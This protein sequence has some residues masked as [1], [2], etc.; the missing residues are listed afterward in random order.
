[1]IAVQYSVS[2]SILSLP[3]IYPL[4]IEPIE[5]QMDT[6]INCA[7]F[8]V[9]S[10]YVPLSNVV[11][12]GEIG[13]LDSSCFH[14]YRIQDRINNE[15]HFLQYECVNFE[16]KTIKKYFQFLGSDGSYFQQEISINEAL[17]E[18]TW[19]FQGFITIPSQKQVSIYLYEQM[20][21]IFSKQIQIHFPLEG[22]N[23]NL[24]IG[25]HFKVS[26]NSPLY[27]YENRLLSFFPGQMDYLLDFF[28]DQPEYFLE[29]IEE[30]NENQCYCLN[31][32]K[33][34]IEDVIIQQQDQF[35]FVSQ[36][37]N[38]DKFLLSGWIK[39]REINS[40]S[41]EFYY[42][43]FKLSGNFLNSQLTQDNLSAFQLLYKI[44]S[45][46]NQ[47]I[48]KSY[49]Y[50]FPTVNI[51]FS[52]NP[53]LKT[54]KFDINCDIQLW[55]YILIEK[56]ET[57]IS[58]SITFY[59]GFDQ[60]Q[61]NLNILVNHFNMVQFKLLYGNILKSKSDYLI[62]Q[63][64]G[65]KFFNCPDINQPNINCHPTCKECDGPTKEDCLSC[66]ELSNRRYLP[67]FKECICQYGTIDSNNECINYQNLNL[68]LVQEQELKKVCQ[69][70]F[71]QFNDECYKCPSIINKNFIT[72]LECVQNPSLWFQTLFCQ[73]ILY[74]DK[75]GNTS[76][77][78]QADNKLY[79]ILVGD[80]IQY[81]PD[82]NSI[83]SSN[84]QVDQIEQLFQF[85]QLCQSIQNNCYQC[86]V[87]CLECQILVTQ[88]ICLNYQ[89]TIY[90]SLGQNKETCK[91][92]N[93]ID[94]YQKCVIC[95]LHH[96]LYCFNYLASDPTKTTLGFY[97]SYSLIDEEIKVGCA[98]CKEGFIFQFS[99]GQCI[100]K[101]Q[102]QQN[103]LRSYINLDENEICTLSD[104]NDFSI[105]LEIINCQIHILNCK[106][107][108]QTLQQT[109]KC[110]ICE[111]GYLVSAN[112]GICIKCLIPN[113]IQCFEDTNL[114]PWK[115]IV[116]GFIIQYLPNRPIFTNFLYRPKLLVTQCIQGYN[117]IMNLCKKYCDEMC[118]IC[119]SDINQ[120]EFYCSKCKLNYF[121]EPTRVQIN[122]K[123][124]QCP[125]LC[126]VC[127]ERSKEEI[128]SI[129]PYFII[130]SENLMYTFRC[131]QKIPS[132]FVHIDPNLQIAQF[133]YENNCNY[134]FE[135][136]IH[137]IDCNQLNSILLYQ[138][139]LYNYQYF[140]EIGLK[141]FTLI[142]HLQSYCVFY[143]H[144]YFIDNSYKENIFSIQYRRLRIQGTPNPIYLKTNYKLLIQKF[145]SIILNELNFQIQ[146]EL[147]LIF[148]ALG[149]LVDLKI[150][151]SQFYSKKNSPIIMSIQGE[152]FLNVNLQNI[153]IFDL[154]FEN[155]VIFQFL[156]DDLGE[157]IIINNFRIQNC[158]F[159]NTTLF[160]FQKARRNIYISNFTIDSCQ[161]YNSSIMHFN[162]LSK[163]N[164][165]KII[166]T[167]SLFKNSNLIYSI[168]QSSLTINN[169][170]IYENL[171]VNSKF[172]IF[173]Y[174][175]Y[176]QNILMKQNQF[177]SFQFMLQISSIL[178]ESTIQMNNIKILENIIQ[179]FSLFVTKQ[180]QSTTQVSF[181]LTNLYFE[182]NIISC[183]QQYFLIN[184]NC[185]S[186][187]I[188]NI[189]LRNT[190][191]YRFISL[192]AVPFIKIEN[193]I[194]ENLLQEQK[195]KI[196][197]DCYKNC[198]SISQL[199]FVSGFTNITLNQIT[200][201]N[202][203]TIDQSIIS[204]SSNPLL[205]L[206][207]N[208]YI[209]IKDLK[210]KGNILIKNNVGIIFS[211]IELY[212]EKPQLIEIE[213][214]KFEE[215]IF[216]QYNKDPS[217]T[218]AS[219]LYVNSVL[220]FMRVQNIICTNNALTNSTQSYIYLFL[221]EI[222][223]ENF[224]VYNH[225]YLVKEFWLQYYEIQLE[226]EYNQNEISYAIQKSFKIETNGG[227]LSS[228]ITKLT[229][230]NGIFQY[231][232][233][234]SS[235]AFNINLQG[236]GIV[237][238]K[239]CSITNAYNSL[240]SKIKND[241]A[242]RINGE[243]SLLSLNLENITFINVQNKLS[244]SLF[245]IYSSSTQN[246]IQ[247]KNIIAQDCFSLV[248]QVINF[249]ADFQNADQNKVKIENF[250][251][252]QNEKA[253]MIFLQS[254]GK[255]TLIEMQKV[256]SDNAIMKF[257]GCELFL[258]GIQIEG[259]ILSSIITVQDSKLI[260]LI[261][262]KF[263][264][265]LTYYPLNLIE[266]QQSNI[267][268]S[269]IY[270]K[271]IKITNYNDKTLKK[272]NLN[273]FD[274][275]HIQLEFSQCSLK[276]NYVAQYNHK[277]EIV[278]DFFDKLFDYS[279]KKGSLIKIKSITNQ[280][281]AFFQNVLFQNNNC[282]YC[283]NGLLFLE[284]ID[285]YQVRI[286]ELSCIK[287]Y[288]KDNG[289]ILA[290]SEQR[291]NSKL[292][293]DHSNFISNNG[294]IGSGIQI[295][296]LIIK[297][298]NSKIINN[299][300]SYKGGGLYF[301][302]DSQRFTIQSTLII[303][304][305]AEQAGGI[306]LSEN[307]SLN[308]NNLIQSLLL[309]NN[310]KLAS[311]NINELPQHLSLS[312]NQMEMQFQYRIIE[313]SLFQVLQLKPY[314]IISQAQVISTNILF[315]PSG[316]QMQNF[317]L[318][319]PK[320]LKFSS[321]ITEFTIKFKNSLNEQQINFLDSTCNI[322]QQ[323]IDIETQNVIESIRVS[324]ISFNKSINS[325]DLGSLTF[326]IDPYKQEDH[327]NEILIYCKTENQ[328]QNLAYRMRIKSF[329]CQLGEF[330]I[331][332]G[333]QK[334]QSEQ[335]FYSVTYNSTKCSIFDKNKFE[336]ITSNKIQL[337]S[338][339]WRPSQITDNVELCYKNPS[340]CLGGWIVGDD[341]CYKGH[342]GGLCEECDRFNVRGDGQFFK[343]QQQLD[344]QQCEQL[345]KRMIAF[346][347]ISIWAILSTLL[348][349][350]SIEKTNQLYVQLKL[351]QNQ[352]F[353]EIL[354]K[355]NQDH[356]SILLKLFLNYFWV[357]SLIFT[358]NINL[359]ISLDF[360]KP[361]SDTSFFMANYFECFLAEIQGIQLIYSRIL[362]MFAL[363]LCQ[364]LIIFFGFQLLQILKCYKF[365][366][367]IIS[368]TVFY[369]YIQ[370]Y[371]SLINQFFSILAI[372]KI[373]DQNYIS[374]DVS[375][376]YGSQNHISW[377]YGFVIPGSLLI[378]LI[379]PLSLFLILYLYKDQHNKIKFRRHIGYLF[380]E[381][382][383]K[384]YFWEIIKLWKKTLIIVILI[385]FETD[386]FLKASLLALCLLIY[387][388]IAQKYKPFIL[389]KFNLLDIQS[390]QFCLIAIFL[391]TVK[392]IMEQQE[393][394]NISFIIQSFILLD[395][396]ILGYPFIIDILKVYYKKFKLQLLSFIFKLLQTLFPNY[397]I[398]KYIRK[399]L[400]LMRQKEESAKIN[401]QKLKQILYLNNTQSPS[402][403]KSIIFTNML[404]GKQQSLLSIE[405]NQE[406]N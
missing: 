331:F 66:F 174:D 399:K 181:L 333:C 237:I 46:G 149:Q 140:N 9:W 238:I 40:Y 147:I 307:S 214:I 34:E 283:W 275:N 396:I 90:L 72:C 120:R 146:A 68:N 358:F 175:F 49:S 327:V 213:N 38:C 79:Y 98:Q 52:K 272:Q 203:F 234:Q 50:T 201:N 53:F 30:D 386:I 28:T 152:S 338:G 108:I 222:L 76:K 261:N 3:S 129:N 113:S 59:Q 324:T 143:N 388:I 374:G 74:T 351:R 378:G 259:I 406:K 75:N 200:I 17:Y 299:T 304:N 289:C 95:E 186:L 293:I 199:I 270:F 341:L 36:Q 278:Q 189:F 257:K 41:D 375:L 196:S 368:I 91:S 48:I 233:A 248:H 119:E 178:L 361:S 171:M 280:T 403:K 286:S 245:S 387:Q 276:S 339:F 348:T 82:C 273:Y 134:N 124:I 264:D 262:S 284:L 58:I 55:H 65:F 382:T 373:S 363:M 133:C 173:N 22:T 44:S 354:F 372:R 405:S 344:C 195:I 159:T 88:F 165:N 281:R 198:D 2:Q 256:I 298:S 346:F 250:R 29:I 116:Q 84:N 45:L 253:L 6:D 92:P 356:E 265:I 314:K 226:E 63:I 57:S 247:I 96:C 379:L 83:S 139:E 71:F 271:D 385:Y 20:S 364:I 67:D 209:F 21:Q 211:L 398:T 369:L 37:L 277:D 18:F 127:Q 23:Y 33:T 246:N 377:I 243:D 164:I 99:S 25:G 105:A 136:D 244:S 1:M 110:L 297:L 154:N 11:Q 15:L 157:T 239:H 132:Q 160:L 231:I 115:W 86:G 212:S 210:M 177:K 224:Q 353:A 61:F 359:S 390:A 163:I 121:K 393:K 302:E 395:S 400:S 7:G 328:E 287:N 313:N 219:L 155:Q 169:I 56:T 355:L 230:I 221:F 232:I 179:N 357:F 362:I 70:G 153:Y 131:N 150:Y 112:T 401:I 47:I 306:Y 242:F 190:Q 170:S 322:N 161:F 135:L 122:G 73:T 384:N 35:Q 343:N 330:Y 168:E 107:C 367:R 216:H 345:L 106:H 229:I 78:F 274:Y 151:D 31:S 207:S 285:F 332:S 254:L 162:Q 305:S 185:Y 87:E 290:I 191:N 158:V 376:I 252:I 241:G 227:A 142:L 54:Q 296:N 316:Q 24:I 80:D 217:K 85:K 394:Q 194:Y 19:Y 137:E 27:T 223:I 360:V 235:L 342:I 183:Q 60:E 317:E 64:I 294:R 228:T 371:A 145:D 202:Q 318:Y 14:L 392:Q 114:E 43:L 349:I 391:A 138:D 100:Y 321:Y 5:N 166:I 167:N 260:T 126:Q 282:Q 402:S 180:K 206:N 350:R 220:S 225:N 308:K 51:D 204:I 101:S 125:S 404:K 62:I 251:I 267:F 309:F 370:N 389:M 263:I 144:E 397:S 193:V 103:C 312:I 111:D 268:S 192:L 188:Q 340:H 255:I 381:Y 12:I 291:V 42:Q 301:Q 329:L 366:N 258:Y 77:Y 8:G 13:I 311:N 310:A 197:S 266:I 123:C 104:I 93:F 10:R 236:D 182:D 39:I 319:N 172:I 187:I 380:N 176:C 323:T 218:S 279:D 130:T 347:L 365:Q 315:I 336:A 320:L 295:K 89:P 215:N 148:G 118:S 128:N 156:C 141:Q 337:K 208:E 325:F 335:G 109:I 269:F 97:E 326:N 69:Y 4:I 303:N 184:I 205:M 81:C 94:F 240:I 16:Q 300:A 102:T 26:Q 117:M 249:E 352:K 288:I 32:A 383:Q 292:L 334:C